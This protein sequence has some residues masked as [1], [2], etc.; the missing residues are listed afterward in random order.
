METLSMPKWLRL[1]LARLSI[2]SAS[3]REIPYGEKMLSPRLN[4]TRI[5]R[6]RS[7]NPISVSRR[8]IRCQR[9]GSG[10]R[11]AAQGLFSMTRAKERGAIQYLF[12]KLSEVK[13]YHW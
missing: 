12:L 11:V 10:L 3:E 2:V 13:V 4:R 9:F 8:L 5:S 1:S 7:L 6:V